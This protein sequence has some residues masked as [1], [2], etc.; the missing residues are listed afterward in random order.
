MDEVRTIFPPI[1]ARP[2]TIIGHAHYVM[3]EVRAFTFQLALSDPHILLVSVAP[4]TISLI[5]T[6][7]IA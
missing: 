5:F 4:L 7:N 6:Y 3:S 1:H 2:K